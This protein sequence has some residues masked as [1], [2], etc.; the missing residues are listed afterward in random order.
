MD[1]SRVLD[2]DEKLRLVVNEI[3]LLPRGWV[4]RTLSRRQV[5]QQL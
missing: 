2:V 1:Q 5:Q 3:G 4:A